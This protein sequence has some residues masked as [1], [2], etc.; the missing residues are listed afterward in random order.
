[1]E[2]LKK[3]LDKLKLTFEKLTKEEKEVYIEWEKVLKEGE[4]V[5][6]LFENETFQK[7]LK[8]AENRLGMLINQLLNFDN[9]REKDIYLKSE[10]SHILKFFAV[11]KG[12]KQ[13]KEILEEQ[14][15]KFL[16]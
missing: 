15:K 16:E 11:I 6:E 1:M 12:S 14:I 2:I 9:T 5:K 10:I 3:Y 4:K 7:S 13:Q 8:E